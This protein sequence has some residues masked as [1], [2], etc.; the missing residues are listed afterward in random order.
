[1]RVDIDQWHIR[2]F[3][4]PDIDAVVKYANNR[5][6]WINLR[7]KFPYPYTRADA[8]AWIRHVRTQEPESNFAI[9]SDSELIG[10]IG[11]QLQQDVHRQSAEIGYWLGEPHWG[12]GIATRAVRAFTEYGFANFPIVR[13]YASVFEWNPASSR[14]LEK[15]GYEYEGRLRKS[16]FKDGKIIDQVIYAALCS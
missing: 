10:G 8:V 4:D 11:L 5:N 16:V 9:A 15:A 6:V 13:I 12:K 3:A 2:K 1:M 14:V 7:D